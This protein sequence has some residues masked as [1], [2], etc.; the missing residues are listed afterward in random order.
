[1][2]NKVKFNI[3]LNGFH[4]IPSNCLDGYVHDWQDVL[5]KDTLA[6]GVCVHQCSNC[7]AKRRIKINRESMTFEYEGGSE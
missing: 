5:W 7:G 2:S 1:M 6:Y 3:R 4:K